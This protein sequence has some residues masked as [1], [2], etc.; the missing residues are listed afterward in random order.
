MDVTV[1]GNAIALLIGGTSV[2]TRFSLSTLESTSTATTL[3]PLLSFTSTSTSAHSLAL[4][5][6]VFTSSVAKTA[7]NAVYINS[8]IT[9]AIN[10]LNC[11]FILAGTA[12]STNFCVGYSGVGSPTIAGINNTSLNVNVLLPQTTAVQSGITQIQYTDI[13]PPVLACYSSSVDQAFLGAVN[14]PQAVTFNTTQFNQGTSLV[15]ST[16]VYVGSQGNYQVSWAVG[17]SHSTGTGLVT[18][19]LKKNGTTI[20]NTGAQT[21]TFSGSS[22][23]VQLS[24]TFILSLNAGDYIE[25]WW[26]TN[27]LSSAINSTAAVN[28]NPA[29]PGAV[30]NVTQIR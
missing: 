1:D 14:T 5:S 12:S 26:N 3:L 16:R 17:F 8:G 18:T 13:N 29:V 7:T 19:F 15:S 2:L 11:V 4:I 9:T 27:A 24:P 25:L 20:A 23:L 22:S 6:F 21:T 10:A 30:I 28:G